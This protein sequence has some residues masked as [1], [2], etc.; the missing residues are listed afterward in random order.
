VVRTCP[1]STPT[2]AERA[3]AANGAEA[4]AGGLSLGVL[5]GEGTHSPRELRYPVRAVAAG[6]LEWVPLPDQ[7]AQ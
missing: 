2:E 7:D 3:V 1:A 4:P 5:V 6:A